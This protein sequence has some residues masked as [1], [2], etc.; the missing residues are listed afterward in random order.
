MTQLGLLPLTL[1][2]GPPPAIWY[3]P[4]L[5]SKLQGLPPFQHVDSWLT[6]G[7]IAL[8]NPRQDEG[9]FVKKR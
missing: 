2:Y 9:P 4:V 6:Y 1:C 5:S 7:V 8:G 3:C